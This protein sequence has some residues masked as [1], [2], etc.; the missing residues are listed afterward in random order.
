MTSNNKKE[1]CEKCVD[2]YYE[3]TWP[4]HTAYYGCTNPICPCHK[5]ENYKSHSHCWEQGDSPACGLKGEHE[6]CCLCGRVKGEKE[7]YHPSIG[8]RKTER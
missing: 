4:T 6:F 2:V 5:G 3:K 7:T 8:K 1:C